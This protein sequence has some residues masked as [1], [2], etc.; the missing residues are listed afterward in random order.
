MATGL[1]RDDYTVGWICAIPIELSAVLAIL[2]ETH[3]QLDIPD[4]DTNV[5]KFGRIGSHN[6]VISCLPGGQYGLTRAAVAAT[7]MRLTFKKLRFG[8]M[9]GVGGGAPSASNDIRLGDIVVSQPTDRSG[10]V[11]QYDFGKATE[12]GEFEQSGSLNA[13]PP[14]LLGAVTVMKTVNDLGDK[15]SEVAQEVGHGNFIFQY[16]GQEM[17]VLFRA[18]YLHVPSKGRQSD[19]C[20]ACEA[21]NIITRPEREYDYPYI[22]YGIIASAN[23]VMKDGIKRDKVSAQTRALCFEMEAAGLMNDFPCLVI[24]GICDYSDG[25]K[26]KRWQPYAALVAAIYAKELLLGVPIASKEES[27]NHSANPKI[28]EMNVIIP[29]RMPFPRNREFVG[30]G[31][32]LGKIHKYFTASRSTDTPRIFALTGTGGMGKTQIAIEYT[33]RHYRDYTAVFWISAASEDT[34]RTSFIDAVQRIV[35]EQ[36]II[37]AESSPDYEV[38]SHKLGISGLI[39]TRGEVS[40]SPETASNI[41]LALFR[42]LQLPGNNS[43]LLIFDN[44]DDLESFDIREYF[45]RHGGGAILITSR[46][47]EFS[48]TAEQAGLDGLDRESAIELLLNLTCLQDSQDAV[49]NE[50]IAIVERLGFMPLA[51]THA[52]CF[53]HE[54]KV[55]LG[56][57]LLYYNEAFMAVQ[58]RLPRFG[59]KYRNDTAVTT[60]EISFSQI[61]KEDR[62]AA[63]LLGICSYLNFEEIYEDLWVDEQSDRAFQLECR[64]IGWISSFGVFSI[65]PVV[66]SWARERLQGPE[67]LQAVRGAIEILGKACERETVSRDSKKWSAR[68]ERRIMFHLGHLQS[69]FSKSV[70]HEETF[71]N[72]TILDAMRAIAVVFLN[73]GKYNEGMRWYERALAGQEKALGKDHPSTLITV[74]DIA[75]VFDDQG[76]YDE[77]MQ[78]YKRVI[79]GE[80]KA[81]GKDH[82][83]ILTTV[84]NIALVFNHQGKYDEAMRWYKR[85]LAG[86]KKALGKD[87]P[88]TLTTVHD[89]ASVFN[90]QGKYNEAMRWYERVIE[91]QEKALG[92]DHPS[93]LTTVHNIASVFNHQGKY[94]E[95][96][97]WYEQ[98]LAGRKKALG[99]DHPSIFTTVHN[100]ALVFKNQGKYDEA[101]RWYERALAGREKALGKDHPSTLTT[102]H[103]IASVFNDQDKYDEAMRWYERVI[104]GQE[105]ALGKDHPSTLTTVHNIASV[106]NH[107]GK[108]DEAMRWYERALAGYEKALG[109]DHP[110][111]LITVHDIALVFEK[112]GKYDEAI[113]WYERVIKGEEKALG[114]DHPSTLITVHNIASVFENQGKYDEAMRWYERALAGREKA[115]GKDHPYTLST[116]KRI[117]ILKDITHSK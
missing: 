84:H 53:I 48:R 36:A 96:I 41:Q 40:A 81:L 38:I 33:Y 3:P 70:M 98:A 39:N 67:R 77:A 30:R 102:V 22:H 49:K 31:D 45:P 117:R 106:F 24:R 80:E 92:K 101:I 89:I 74:H 15:I 85:A 90:N 50:V 107:Q 104:K 55:P 56:E 13:P 6:V 10:G 25:H 21:S 73:Q 91:G 95:A 59:W 23:Q 26:N 9:V 19:T 88:S 79:E 44:A 68:E 111:T 37:Q 62:E 108:Y 46:R 64:Y 109:K 16:P 54:T 76:K 18:D 52:S 57:Y 93:T 32:D 113:R 2:D 115:L 100:I 28:K 11:I 42:W 61:E 60:W 99:K 1:R 66:H 75:S 27:E 105:K 72:V 112:Q 103:D 63:M 65:H 17:D 97:Q 78:W 83:S 29:L 14:V 5:Y 116:A 4:G 114:K 35:E 12:S 87:H 82:P 8:L 43:W 71:E 7:C 58:S 51:I 34:I 20:R 47:P 94:N 69:N 110:S 86:Y